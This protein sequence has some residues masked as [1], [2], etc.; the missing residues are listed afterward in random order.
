MYKMRVYLDNGATTKV[1]E[2][3]LQEILP[4]FTVK[5]GNASSLHSFGQEAKKALEEARDI[6]AK[7]INASPQEIVF[8]SG[9]SEANNT[10]IKGVAYANKDKGNHIITSKIEHP[11]VFGTLNDLQK[12]GF[13]ITYLNVDEEGFVDLEQLKREIN[14]NTILVTIMHANNEIG[15]IEPIEEI[16]KI[17][18]EKN[19]PFHT[20]AVQ[21]FTKVPLDVKKMN[22]DLASF[23]AH[24]IHGPKGVGALYI[25]K[26][27]KIKKL[28]HGGSQ[29]ASLRAGTENIA[30]I[31]GFAKAAT[32]T[33]KRDTEKITE[34]RDS[35]IRE[36]EK[37]IPEVKLNGPRKNRLCN[38]INISFKFIE[39]EGLLMRLDLERI[40]V[41]T[42]SACSQRDLKPSYVLLSIGLN[43]VTSHG[44]I[45]FTLSRYTTEKEMGYTIQKLK[46][47]VADLRKIS[48]LA[49]VKK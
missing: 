16:G 21:S 33:T 38:N 7:Q 48:P 19:I 1:A 39:G 29:E 32:L 18:M 3:V 49:E 9:G 14:E 40:A 36:I 10:A 4:Y 24:K 47:I 37:Q 42:G 5:Y 28:I 8:T 41:S 6:I 46:K 15:T 20:D 25:K 23:S 12:D 22:I 34:L 17:C 13:K 43:H 2:E 11:S 26:G 35:F 44:S 45:R 31:V 30:G 27:T